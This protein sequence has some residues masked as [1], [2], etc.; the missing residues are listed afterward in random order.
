[1]SKPKET[2]VQN[3]KLDDS[4]IENIDLENLESV[5]NLDISMEVN[6]NNSIL[7]SS[8]LSKPRSSLDKIRA[9]ICESSEDEVECE[10]DSIE[11]EEIKLF[12]P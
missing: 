6:N 12:C 4:N 5:D 8:I 11:E 10:V 2:N 3:S 1:M 9:E 7:D